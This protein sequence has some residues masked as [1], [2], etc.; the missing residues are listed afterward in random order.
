MCSRAI[1]AGSVRAG[2]RR[3]QTL[4]AAT[5]AGYFGAKNRGRRQDGFTILEVSV[6]IGIMLV[7]SAMAIP[8]ITTVVANAKLRGA[9]YDLSGIIQK[10]RMAAVQNNTTYSVAFGT[11]NGAQG[12]WVDYNNDGS[13]TSNPPEPTIQFARL[14][15]QVAAPNGTGG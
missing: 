3:G 4:S 11:V 6:V 5:S 9:A 1:Q 13:Y 8:S 7:I 2:H 15:N 14:I 10:C 12:A